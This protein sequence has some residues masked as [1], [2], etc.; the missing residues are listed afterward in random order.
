MFSILLCLSFHLGPVQI[1][2]VYPW[3]LAYT[4]VLKISVWC[5][6]FPCGPGLKLQG[7]I[8][9]LSFAHVNNVSIFAILAGVGE[10]W[11][12]QSHGCTTT[13]TLSLPEPHNS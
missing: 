1:Q 13:I 7:D 12:G 8:L 4:Q 2:R 9:C 10:E 6:A 5:G 3:S 11:G